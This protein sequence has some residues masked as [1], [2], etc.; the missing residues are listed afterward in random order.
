MALNFSNFMVF[1]KLSDSSYRTFDYKN[2][3]LKPIK[4]YVMIVINL[5]Y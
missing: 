3:E 2:Q 5:K 1:Y 4:N